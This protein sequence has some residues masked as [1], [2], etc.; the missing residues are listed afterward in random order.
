MLEIKIS[1]AIIAIIAFLIAN[2]LGLR[3]NK[4]LK[5]F[6]STMF[7]LV[8]LI[9]GIAFVAIMLYSK[10]TLYTIPRT[11]LFISICM[12]IRYKKRKKFCT[13]AWKIM[14][15]TALSYCTLGLA[16]AVFAGVEMTALPSYKV[17]DITM[18]IVMYVVLMIILIPI[19]HVF[20]TAYP[21]RYKKANYYY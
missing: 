20:F 16:G 14:H 7:D 4:R 13:P 15:M 17:E 1:T 8:G 2:K 9:S 10:I 3:R 12:Y 21:S 11:L 5:K 18:I 6:F 19:T